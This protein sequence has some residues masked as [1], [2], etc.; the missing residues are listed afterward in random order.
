M[1]ELNNGNNE[2]NQVPAEK[3]S[4]TEKAKRKGH[5]YAA[6]HPKGAKRVKRVVEGAL[7]LGSA[8]L[9]FVLGKKSVKPVHIEVHPIEPETTE[10]VA[11]TE[12]TPAEEVETAE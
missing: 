6:K 12:E 9:G 1:S 4:L 8:A 3:I 7:M 2:V 5:E 10:P 11:Q